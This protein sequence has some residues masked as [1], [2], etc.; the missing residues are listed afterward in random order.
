M[1]R[2]ANALAR[3][4]RPP[5]VAPA[6][7]PRLTSKTGTT[8]PGTWGHGWMGPWSTPKANA[9]VGTGSSAAGPAIADIQARLPD[10]Q[11]ADLALNTTKEDPHDPSIAAMP[12]FVRGWLAA[13]ASDVAN[14]AMEKEAFGAAYADPAVSSQ[15]PGYNCWIALA[16]EAAG[17]PDKAAAVLK[18]AGTY[19]DCY[20]FR[21]DI[22]DGRGGWPGAQKA[23]ADAVALAPNLPAPYY[24]WGVALARHG[25][26]GGAEAKFK[27]A[28]L[29]GPH[30]ADPLK[31]C[32]PISQRWSSRPLQPGRRMRPSRT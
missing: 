23:Y 5:A 10:P 15:S 22:L 18:S 12:H 27:D 30:W 17:H 9:G 24:S 25:E 2:P 13:A 3:C 31:A 7:H 21:A 1:K 8:S 11:A 26:L 6:E 14:A 19:V 29:R 16:E 32:S 20:C 4:A 28:N